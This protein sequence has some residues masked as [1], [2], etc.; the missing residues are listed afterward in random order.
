[1]DIILSDDKLRKIY[2]ARGDI[3]SI[4]KEQ[5]QVDSSIVSIDIL[6]ASRFSGET[7]GEL[8]FTYLCSNCKHTFPI[9]FKRCHNCLAVNSEIVEEHITKHEKADYSLF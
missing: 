8:S 6:A 3:K 1:M 5:N 7:R 2:Y 4:T 9:T